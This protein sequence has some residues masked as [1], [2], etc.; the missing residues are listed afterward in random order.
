MATPLQYSELNIKTSLAVFLATQ[1]IG[2]GY[3]VYWHRTDVLQT[4]TS[5]TDWWYQYSANRPTYQ[6]NGTYAAKV[7]AAKGLVTMVDGIPAEPR[8]VTRLITD[9]SV[10]PAD[11]VPVPAVS[12]ELS[13]ELPQ[14]PYELGSTVMWRKRHLLLDIYVRDAFEQGKFK[15]WLAV[16]LQTDAA[17]AVAEYDTGSATPSIIGS[18]DVQQLRIDSARFVQGAQALTYQV[19]VNAFVSYVA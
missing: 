16:W 13:G 19:M 6:G 18:V 12:V 8:F 5:S 2:Q 11:E 9:S 4:G 10:G 3:L 17:I 15:D 7:A 14:D 1:L